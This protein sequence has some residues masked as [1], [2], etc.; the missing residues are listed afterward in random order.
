MKEGWKEGGREEGKVH[1]RERGE[2][3]RYKRE[4]GKKGKC[5]GERGGEGDTGGSKMSRLAPE[6]NQYASQYQQTVQ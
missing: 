6:Q 3:V 2:G 1:R 5:I 4:G